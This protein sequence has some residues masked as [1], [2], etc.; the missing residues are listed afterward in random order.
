MLDRLKQGPSPSPHRVETSDTSKDETDASQ[1]RRKVLSKKTYRMKKVYAATELGRFFVT[2]PSPSDAADMPS[3]F[4]C[5]LC[6]KN[7]SVLTHGHHEVLRHFQGRRHFARDQ[8]LR[9]E[10]PGWRVLDFQGNPLT[11]D[12]LERQ[13]EKIQ[14]GPL[15]VRDR[16]HPF[17]KDLISDEAGVIDPQLPVLTKVS[18]L[19]DGLKMGGSYGPIEKLWAQFVLTAVPVKREVAWTRDEVLIRS[20]D[21]RNLFVSFL[22]HIVVLLL[23][24]YHYWNAARILSR[25]VGWAKAYHFYG[26]EFEER[27]ESLWAFMRTWEKG[28]FRRVVVDVVDRFTVDASQ[29]V[30]VLGSVVAA[31][32]SSASLVAISGG[33]HVLADTYKEYL[34]SGYSHKLVE[35]PIFDLRLLKRC[36][37]KVSSSVFGSLDPFSMTKFIVT[38]L[39]GAE[40]RDL[41]M[42]RTSLRRAIITGELSMPSLV[43]VVSNIVGVWPLIVVYLK[44]TGR[45]TDGDRLVV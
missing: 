32:G 34:G 21:F 38:R 40:H 17:A 16:E 35:Y 31:V 2:G 9:L 29:D 11:E 39:N 6:R 12:E 3:H 25:V 14:K 45:K 26:L 4:Y 27:G 20:V 36:L 41:M 30:A 33:S 15:V 44:E 18:C 23:V 8:P 13:R 28:T 24:N 42:S 22:I 43:E 1:G 7:V 19:V 10:T 5:R 37:Q